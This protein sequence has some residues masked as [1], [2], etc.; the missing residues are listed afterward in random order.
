MAIILQKWYTL[1]NTTLNPSLVNLGSFTEETIQSLI[2]QSQSE[3]ENVRLL[4]IEAMVDRLKIRDKQQFVQVHQAMLI[5]LL[6][7]LYSYKQAERLNNNIVHLFDT[8]SQHMEYALNFIE[9][10]F[11]QYFDRNEKVPAAYLIVSM[12]ELFKQLEVLKQVLNSNESIDIKL[13]DILI[14]N[15]SRFVLKKFPGVTYNELVYQKDLLS[16]LLTDETLGSESSIQQVLFYFNFNDDDYISYLYGKL[17]AVMEIFSTKKEK[18]T[19]LRFEQKN[20]NQL[21]TKLNSYLSASMPSLKEQVNHW[22]EEEVKFLDSEQLP[23]VLHKPGSESDE[24][25][26]TSLSVA[27]L[28]LLIRLMITDNIIVNRV[29]TQVLRIVI[30]TVATAQKENISFG[31]LETKYHNPDKGTINAVKE[32]LF[33]WINLLNKM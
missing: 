4:F 26:H 25:V 10:F 21:T 31:S 24:K 29:I 19:A 15:F 14:A 1:I 20:L 13:K 2:F 22:I 3:Q 27:K 17:K 28:A 9:D 12:D 11:S 32:I 30:R 7:K 16:E 5:R 8:I 23:E 18:I 6:D 33:R